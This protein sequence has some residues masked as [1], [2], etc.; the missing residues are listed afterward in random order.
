MVMLAPFD[1]L[2]L[3]AAAC[4]AVG[5]IMSVT[6]A[7]HLGAFAFSRWRMLMVAVMLWS[8][9]LLTGGWHS[10]TRRFLV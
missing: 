4:W 8:V 9:S 5:S 6:P 1:L 2:A 7:R 3:G 10:L